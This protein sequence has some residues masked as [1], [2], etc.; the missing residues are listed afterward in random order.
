MGGPLFVS[1]IVPT[2]QRRDLV[3]HAVASVLAQTQRHLELI[4]VDDGST[5]GTGV[6]LAG[7][8]ER[9]RYL[10]QE[11]RGVS[12]ARNAG[13]REARGSV[14]AFLDSDN[15]WLP[16]HLEVVLGALARHP[17]AVLAST[18]PD[19]LL[20]GRERP[21]EAALV[22][23]LP[24]ALVGNTVGF[25]SCVAV[26]RDALLTAGG[27]DE[28]LMVAEDNDLWTRLALLGPFSYVRR[29]TVVRGSGP[30]SLYRRGRRSG[31]HLTAVT[32]SASR[33]AE[34]V[35]RL[36]RARER[37]LVAPAQGAACFARA[38]GAV[39]GDDAEAARR[40]LAE[41][42]RLMPEL[43]R[44]PH[45]VHW[46]LANTVPRGPELL[47][48]FSL[49]AALWPDPR[50]DAALLLRGYALALALRA[51]DLRAAAKLAG[52]PPFLFRPGL[53][54]LVLPAVIRNHRRR[55]QHRQ[56]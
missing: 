6:T 12:A 16:D 54:R 28:R 32:L 21:E 15:R 53:A 37:G 39:V 5:D 33:I 47:R 41:A 43:S 55:V 30:D 45:I 8:D 51:G 35:E 29:R 48:V 50:S 46:R 25:L 26:R 22:E 40:E 42:C 19:F 13:I 7:L 9:L 24:Q 2:Y 27:F 56:A 11:N 17:Q 36:P 1:V 31:E 4:V 52:A 3:L 23:P 18:C 44:L 14:V 34:E 49:A 38:L 10:W 20:S